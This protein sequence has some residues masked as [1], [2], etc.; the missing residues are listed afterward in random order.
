MSLKKT[1][2]SGTEALIRGGIVLS[3][4]PHCVI[5]IWSGYIS[6]LFPAVPPEQV[7]VIFMSQLSRLLFEQQISQHT[8]L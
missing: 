8:C 7:L 4:S 1:A 2:E 5:E 3:V 6:N